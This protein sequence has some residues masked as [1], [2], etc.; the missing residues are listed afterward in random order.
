MKPFIGIDI[1]TD[2]K[3]EKMNGDEFIVATPSLALTQSFERSLESSTD[4]IE[5]SKLP[6]PV[7]IIQWICGI[8]AAFIACGI[9]KS[10]GGEDSITLAEAYQNASWLF[11]IGGGCLVVWGF[12]KIIS[13]RKE[14]EVLDTEESDLVF[15]HLDKSSEAI[16]KDLAV[17]PDAKEIDV[18]TFFYKTKGDEIK[19]CEKAFMMA[20]YMNPIFHIFADLENLYLANLEGKYAFPLSAIKGIKTV[21][22]ATRIVE[23]NKDDPFN[24]GIYKQYKLSEDKYGCITCKCHHIIE[25]EHN[26]ETW[27]IY[28]PSYELAV[29]E[30][31]I[32][33]KT[34]C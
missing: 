11:W 18:L 26:G 31:L 13:L 1:S 29:I 21:N 30:E 6:L 10:L 33:I 2:K 4:T 3:N 17:P 22:K 20:P 12:L 9:L 27:G 25:F 7:R 23:W 19:V 8:L 16:L 32:G 34:E 15:D 24:K 5:K 28:I 14:K